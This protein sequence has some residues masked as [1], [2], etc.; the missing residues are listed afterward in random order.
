MFKVLWDLKVP[1]TCRGHSSERSCFFCFCKLIVS[2]DLNITLSLCHQV[3]KL[4]FHEKTN[5][6]S[7][8]EHKGYIYCDA[9]V[10]DIK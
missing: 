6:L 4:W 2:E 1:W 9:L 7:L 8:F 5:I 3:I 10:K